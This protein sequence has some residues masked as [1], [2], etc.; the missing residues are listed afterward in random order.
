MR[1]I[2]SIMTSVLLSMLIV[3]LS[4]GLSFVHCCHAGYTELAQAAEIEHG[5]VTHQ[6]EP[7]DCCEDADRDCTTVTTLKLAQSDIAHQQVF[8]F[9]QLP[10]IIPD[11][12]RLSTADVSAIV[13]DVTT[14]DIPTGY[15]SPPRGYLHIIRIL[16]I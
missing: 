6:H 14:C 12:F 9:Q 15:K 5:Y 7:Q 16:L 8:D 4:A 11:F 10:V 1:K 13:A 2:C 3:T